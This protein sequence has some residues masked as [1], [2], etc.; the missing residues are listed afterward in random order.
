MAE[1]PMTTMFYAAVLALLFVALG[2]RTI[3]RRRSVGAS[4]GDGGDAVL[5]RRI[6]AHG[7]FAE[8]APFALLLMA[9]A[10]AGGAPDWRIHI[11]GGVL[12]AGRLAHAVGVSREPEDFRFRVGGMICTFSALIGGALTCLYLALTA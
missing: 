2:A 11:L 9:L 12:L 10:E 5:T 1:A 7:N 8:Y 3:L 6:R 4:L